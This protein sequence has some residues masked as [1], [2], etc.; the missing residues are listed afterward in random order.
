MMFDVSVFKKLFLIVYAWSDATTVLIAVHAHH[1]QFVL[2][3][4][5]LEQ[6]EIPNASHSTVW[7]VPRRLGLA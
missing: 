7:C 3:R 6:S 5:K 1:C 2:V 4:R